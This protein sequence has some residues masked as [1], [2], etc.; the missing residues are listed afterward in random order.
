MDYLAEVTMSILQKQKER[1]PERGYA[2]DFVALADELLPACRDRNVRIVTNAGGVHPEACRERLVEIA[3][4]AGLDGLRVATVTGDDLLP[5]FEALEKRGVRFEHFETGAPIV[6]IRDRLLSANA[7]L[8]ADPIVSAL[9]KGADIVITGRVYDA[10]LTLGPLVHEFGWS[11]E[12]WNRLAAGV[13]A[14]HVLECGAQATGGNYTDWEE[15]PDLARIGFPIVEVEPAGSFTVTKHPDLG[16]TVTAATV[17]EQLLY[18]IGDPR[19]YETPDCR[20]DFTTIQVEEVGPNRVRLTGIEGG[21]PPK[22]Y[23]VS[24]TYRDGWKAHATLTYSWPNAPRKARAS[25]RILEARL[26][27][28]GFRY[29]SFRSEVVGVDALAEGEA[30]SSASYEERL[31]EVM[32]R[33]GVRASDRDAVERFGREIAPL[34]LTGPSG[35]TGYGGPRPRPQEVLAFWPTRVPARFVEPEVQVAEVDA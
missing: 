13:V 21:P 25:A 8:G 20:A 29:D 6:E 10:G 35:V 31:N 24:A 18:E 5:R 26:E 33:V 11:F 23:T 34:V 12:D 2:R 28:A 16:G 9:E 19:A 17:K 30:P 14:G 15:V 27:R 4:D 1:D 3:R 7:Y 22:A 32:L